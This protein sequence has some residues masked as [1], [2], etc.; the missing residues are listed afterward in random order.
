MLYA[1][2]HKGKVVGHIEAETGEAPSK[3]AIIPRLNEHT[4]DFISDDQCFLQMANSCYGLLLDSRGIIATVF[5][6]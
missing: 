3:G 1:I 6:S 2:E 4:Q 5:R